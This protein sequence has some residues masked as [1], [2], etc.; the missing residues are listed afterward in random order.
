MESSA[1]DVRNIFEAMAHG[2]SLLSNL[3]SLPQGSQKPFRH[4]QQND[5]G[6]HA[7][8]IYFPSTYVDQTELE[9]FDKAP[10]GKYTV[11][12]G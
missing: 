6:I 9:A 3:T 5:V 1:K 8:E 12:L 11:G 7:M 4:N 2:G 10:K